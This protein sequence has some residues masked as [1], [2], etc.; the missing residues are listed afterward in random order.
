LFIVGIEGAEL[1]QRKAQNYAQR[2]VYMASLRADVNCL[3]AEVHVVY[4]YVV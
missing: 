3:R 2:C 4:I 1:P